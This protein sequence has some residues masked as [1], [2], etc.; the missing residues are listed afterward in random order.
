MRLTVFLNGINTLEICTKEG[1]TTQAYFKLYHIFCIILILFQQTAISQS[2]G[3]DI[4]AKL[5]IPGLV[6]GNAANI[7]L[8]PHG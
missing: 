1:I 4:V 6:S 3:F 8:K 2:Y 5:N 7:G